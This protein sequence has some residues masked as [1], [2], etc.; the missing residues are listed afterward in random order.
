M[1]TPGTYRQALQG[2]SN[3]NDLKQ[4]IKINIVITKH[5]YKTLEDH[6]RFLL[7]FNI[8]EFRFTMTMIEGNVKKDVEGVVEKMSIIAPYI[9]RAIDIAKGKVDCFVYNMVPCLMSQHVRYIND[10]GRLDTLLVGP[11]FESSLDESRKNRKVKSEKCSACKYDNVCYGV[12][13]EY[14][15]AFGLDELEPV[16]S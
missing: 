11:E 2:I 12:W 13:K 1:G 4:I 5:N 8:T 15:D 16:T 3:L 6:I 14:A 10:M 9:C 7:K